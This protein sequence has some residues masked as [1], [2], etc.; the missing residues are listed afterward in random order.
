MPAHLG[1]CLE[2]NGFTCQD[3]EI[4]WNWLQKVMG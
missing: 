2:S 3:D 4:D 1:D